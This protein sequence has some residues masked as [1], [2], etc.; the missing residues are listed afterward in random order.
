MTAP[1]G[2]TVFNLWDGDGGSDDDLIGDYPT[3][4]NP[5]SGTPLIPS[6][7][8]DFSELDGTSPD[9]TWTL[10]I[11]DA[12]PGSDDGVL[13]MWCVNGQIEYA[14]ASGMSAPGTPISTG[15]ANSIQ[16]TIV[17]IDDTTIG[18]MTVD[19][20]ISHTW[21]GDLEIDVT[22]PALTTVRLI[23]NQFG[24]TAN[25][26]GTYPGGTNM[27]Q[28]AFALDPLGAGDFSEFFGETTAGNWVM[29]INDTAFGDGGALNSWGVNFN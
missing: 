11:V 24:N 9:G 8:G 13:N 7:N 16:D 19:V 2:V 29:D 20:D 22:S 15:A 4:V 28:T 26:I 21:V 23:D 3:G 25:L 5:S 12:F 6:G 17:I 18:S 1:D 10:D 14:A 27:G